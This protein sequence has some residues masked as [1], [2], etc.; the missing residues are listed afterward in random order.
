MS[1]GAFPPNRVNRLAIGRTSAREVPTFTS[2]AAALPST[3][4][5]LDGR[6]VGKPCR[7]LRRRSEGIAS[8]TG[9]GVR[10][11]TSVAYAV[12]SEANSDWPSSA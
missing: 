7:I 1:Q 4:D 11:F 5:R 9:V 6:A 2:R 12:I 8:A 10:A 3:I